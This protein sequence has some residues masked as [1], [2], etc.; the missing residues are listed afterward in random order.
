[1]EPNLSNYPQSI[2]SIGANFRVN[3]VWYYGK[4]GYSGDVDWL[5]DS[6]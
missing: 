3:E 1:M 6:Y 4:I 2:T 5:L